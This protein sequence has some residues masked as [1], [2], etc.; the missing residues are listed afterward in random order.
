[1]F[2]KTH[3]VKK[4][5]MPHKM[6]NPGFTARSIL[7]AMAIVFTVVS[8]S[9]GR[10]GLKLYSVGNNGAWSL[11]STW[12]LTANGKASIYVPQSNDTLVIDRTVTQNVNFSFGG[13]GKL[14]VLN[15]GVLRGDN[16]N[17]VFEGNSE[18]RCFGEIKINNLNINEN[19]VF[20]VENEGKVTVKNSCVNNSA[21]N[22][23]V[24]GKLSVTGTFTL[25]QK[26]LI[27]GAGAIESMYYNGAGSALGV[28]PA[29]SIPDGAVISEYNWTGLINSNWNDAQN[30]A[31]AVVP[32]AVSNVSILPSLNN[33]EVTGSAVANHLFVNS[34][35]TLSVYPESVININGTLAVNGTGRFLLKN[36]TNKKSA[37]FLNGDASGNIQ[38]EYQVLKGKKN[39]VSSPVE[40]AYSRIFL[41]M[42]L[43]TYDETSGQWGQYI[44]PTNDPLQV[45]QGYEL[46]S[47]S[48]E[49][50]TFEGT[51]DQEPKSY[52]ISNSGNGLN[53][54]GNPYPCYIDWEDNDNNAW[55]RNSIASAIYYPDPSGSGN[56]SVYLPGG[57]DAVSLNNGS[58]FIAPMQGFFVKASKEGSLVVNN[59]SR[60]SSLNETRPVVKNNS[61]KF[62]LKDAA[63]ASDEV[64]FRVLSNSTFGF[65]D[66]LDAVKIPNDTEAP[67]LSL[68]SDDDAKYAVNTV[69]SVNSSLNVPVIVECKKA[70]QFSISATGSF[71][72][73]FRYPVIL[74]DKAL[75]KFIDLRADSVYT[76]YQAPEMD[77]RRFELHF[78]SP[79]GIEETTGIGQQVEDI[80]GVTII[81][82]EV[83]VNGNDNKVY[84]ATLFTAEGKLIS[85]SKGSLSDGIS[86]TTGKYAPGLCI[87]RL[88]D[89]I[90]TQTKKIISK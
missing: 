83:T 6:F 49:T 46:Y 23:M 70:G 36:T 4:T 45:M 30:W 32:S 81:P 8:E 57:D 21:A 13:Y 63:G 15:N 58:R 44:V 55:E 34:G 85:S 67:S 59:K 71:G 19:A 11:S 41:N 3:S 74:E 40:M 24:S 86:L 33:P 69:P 51:P 35:A 43:R 14:L 89:G 82:G 64:L 5:S 54:T 28:S 16:V 29:S 61:I 66:K 47:L 37:L 76:F 25:G 87:L 73:E 52:S 90:H 68:K 42:Y 17:L 10:G 18:L 53:L 31:G 56:F 78:Y 20:A 7:I 38:S 60:V 48:S 79:A 77:P 75:G 88:S 50:R 1:L 27:K 9:F 72:F 26:A 84:T 12:A 39:L 22:H 62:K 65:D 80:S 2:V